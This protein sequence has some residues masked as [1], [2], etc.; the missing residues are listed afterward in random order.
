MSKK[1]HEYAIG[2]ELFRYA[3]GGGVFR[4]IVDGRREYDGRVQLEVE[5]QNCSHGW[6]CRLLL[7]QDDYGRIVEIHML[8]DDEEN[9]QRHWHVNEGLHFWPTPEQARQEQVRRL[10]KNAEEDVRK[11][12]GA[13]AAAKRRLA[14]Y[15]DLAQP[16]QQP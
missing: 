1:I 4:Y 16:E 3:V 9:S 10:V 15:K 2:D 11:A 14:Q 12:E 6:K 5:C 7:A 8:N 13:L